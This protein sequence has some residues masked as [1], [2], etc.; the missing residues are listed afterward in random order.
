MIKVCFVAS[1]GE[2]AN[3]VVIRSTIVKL[4]ICV[5]AKVNVSSRCLILS[6]FIAEIAESLFA[7]ENISF[8]V[9]V[10]QRTRRKK[11]KTFCNADFVQA[12]VGQCSY[13]GDL[14]SRALCCSLLHN[15]NNISV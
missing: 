9:A 10:V 5:C 14:W 7:W 4:A 12:L 11:Y 13:C 6:Q 2:F 8:L 15:N 3:C 1:S